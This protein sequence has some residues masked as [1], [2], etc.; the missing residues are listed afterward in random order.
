MREN[1]EETASYGYKWNMIVIFPVRGS[2]IAAEAK[3]HLS[4]R[5]FNSDTCMR[6]VC[7]CLRHTQQINITLQH[8]YDMFVESCLCLCAQQIK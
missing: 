7:M 3:M 8:F 2:P 1:A 5:K 6:G 4:I